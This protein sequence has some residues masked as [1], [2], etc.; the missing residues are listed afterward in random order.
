M[1][2][3]GVRGARKTT[4]RV[5]A[6]EQQDEDKTKKRTSKFVFQLLTFVD[7]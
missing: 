7:F 6:R 4:V 5:G 3:D 2:R 1:K